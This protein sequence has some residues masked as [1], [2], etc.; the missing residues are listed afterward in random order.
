MKRTPYESRRKKWSHIVKEVRMET[1]YPLMLKYMY[2][3]RRVKS[4]FGL[5]KT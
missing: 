4:S 1:Q 2:T 3:V 5:D